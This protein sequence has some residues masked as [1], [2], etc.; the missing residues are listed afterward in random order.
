MLNSRQA[1]SDLLDTLREGVY[2]TDV[3]RSISY[4]NKG[5]EEIT[6]FPAKEVIKHPCDDNI[7]EHV[8]ANGA[9]LCHTGC[10]LDQVMET[11]ETLE[12]EG[13]IQHKKGHR[14]PVNIRA[15]PIR[16]AKG[17][18]QGACQVFG[19]IS[20]KISHARK[21]AE[22]EK[23]AM[24]DHLTQLANRRFLDMKLKEMLA[25]TH[26]ANIPVGVMLY[27]V[28]HFKNFNDEHGHDVGDL[29]LQ[30]VAKT[31]STA[32]RAPDVVGRWGGEEF[33]QIT[34][35][36][37]QEALM[38]VAERNC[39]LIEQSKLTIRENAP[40]HVTA[41]IGLTVAQP[42]DTPQSLLKRADQAL[43]QSKQKGRN[44]ASFY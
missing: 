3:Q 27:D 33:L 13:Y 14:I 42:G 2:M 25:L 41:S 34:P 18:L 5:A 17:E 28:D 36:I 11:G 8:D 22:L 16:D 6:G 1:L 19:D 32:A 15:T 9:P 21:M 44:R 37:D 35:N 24:V 38:A 23:L 10:P 7:L 12:V 31:L 20:S 4:W 26:S 39:A 40:L 29:V 30:M 43:Y